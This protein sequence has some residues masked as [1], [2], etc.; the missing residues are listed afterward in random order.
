MFRHRVSILREF[1]LK[2]SIASP[3]L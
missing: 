2:K 3:A 1:F